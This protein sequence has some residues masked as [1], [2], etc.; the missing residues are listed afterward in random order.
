MADATGR[1]HTEGTDHR[2]ADV[3]LAIVSAA[4]DRHT[5]ATLP[6]PVRLCGHRRPTPGPDR[7]QWD[8]AHPPY[9]PTGDIELGEWTRYRRVCSTSEVTICL[10]CSRRA[11]RRV[12]WPCPEYAHLERALT[13]R[14]D[15]TNG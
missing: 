1:H 13:R 12:M 2:T 15:D 8:K 14:N 11:N 4:L 9:R 5:P 7:D 6:T 10:G 3:L